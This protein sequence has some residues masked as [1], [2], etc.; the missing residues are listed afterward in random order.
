MGGV[1]SCSLKFVLQIFNTVLCVTFLAVALLGI[2]LKSS[3]P[4]VEQLL[5]K[6][7]DEFKVGDDDLHIHYA[8]VWMTTEKRGKTLPP[9][10]CNGKS[11]GCTLKTAESIKM[12][13]CR[14]KIV[15]FT[16]DN[17]KFLLY[18][19]IVAILLKTAILPIVVFAICL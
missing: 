5:A 13:G 16:A 7:F 15:Q 18:I 12:P 6:I 17:L 11:G 9:Q 14:D 1:I 4:V 8:T 2:L 3:R 19:S 10:R